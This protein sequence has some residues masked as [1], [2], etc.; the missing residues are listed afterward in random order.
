MRRG[1]GRSPVPARDAARRR[2]TALPPGR[3]N[4]RPWLEGDALRQM[5]GLPHDAFDVLARTMAGICEDPYDRLF[6]LTAS[7]LGSDARQFAAVVSTVRR[8]HREAGPRDL[9]TDSRAGTRCGRCLSTDAFMVGGTATY[10]RVADDCAACQA[11]SGSASPGMYADGD[12]GRAGRQRRCRYP[13]AVRRG[14]GCGV[15]TGPRAR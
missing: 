6:S 5:G 3:V 4:D 7:H 2:A 1:P 12:P 10:G 15:R 11:T 9:L 13:L 8:A 14:S